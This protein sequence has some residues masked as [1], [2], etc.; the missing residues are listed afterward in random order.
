MTVVCCICELIGSVYAQFLLNLR[1]GFQ[2]ILHTF[3]PRANTADPG[4]VPGPI[5]NYLINNIIS[6]HDCKPKPFFWRTLTV[7][8]L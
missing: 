3:A 7:I 4:P 1:N 8:A 2:H 5:R 6:L